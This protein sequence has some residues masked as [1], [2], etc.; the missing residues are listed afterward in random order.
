MTALCYPVEEEVDQ[1]GLGCVD[2]FFKRFFFGGKMDVLFSTIQYTGYFLLF[3]ELFRGF[4]TGLFS[5]F[6]F[7]LYLFHS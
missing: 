1:E 3:P 6:R 4:L 5:F 2:Q 7:D